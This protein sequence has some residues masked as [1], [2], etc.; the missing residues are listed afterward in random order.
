MQIIAAAQQTG[1]PLG[2]NYGTPIYYHYFSQ[3]DTEC[4]YVW[5]ATD[6]LKQL[7]FNRS[8]NKFDLTKT[9]R[10]TIALSQSSLYGPVLT[11]SSDGTNVGTGIVWVLR[12]ASNFGS[13][14]LL[15]AYDARD[16]RHLLWSSNMGTAANRFGN[17]PKFNTA[18]VANGKVYVPSFSNKLYIY[19][20]FKPH[21]NTG[22]FEKYSNVRFA[23]LY[24][25]PTSESITLNY[26]LTKPLNDL[27]VRINDF[28]GRTLMSIPLL[29]T[30]GEH[31][32]TISLNNQ[33]KPGIY[34]IEYISSENLYGYSRFIKY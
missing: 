7:F 28:L 27:T 33:F 32:Q 30:A 6:S 9:I 12:S 19:G 13:Q 22:I 23:N 26:N 31:T 5:A 34:Y 1:Y 20:L 14:G 11:V 24:P 25:N 29:S 2:L 17:L 10:G 21:V 16:I 18:V 3:S 15:E 8:G 4:I